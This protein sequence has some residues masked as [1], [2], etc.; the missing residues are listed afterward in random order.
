MHSLVLWKTDIL[1][2]GCWHLVSPHFYGQADITAEFE[3]CY[4]QAK[5]GLH[6]LA[7]ELAST[8]QC[9]D[10]SYRGCIDRA[11]VDLAATSIG[12]SALYQSQRLSS[13]LTMQPSRIG[14]HRLESDQKEKWRSK[15]DA[16]L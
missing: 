12:V 1:R 6:E 2:R 5:L 8:C 14:D 16:C 10:V 3:R 15:A 9:G 11:W 7:D 4:I 13:H